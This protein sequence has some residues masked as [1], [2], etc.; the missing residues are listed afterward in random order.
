MRLMVAHFAY[1]QDQGVRVY[2]SGHL[3]RIANT[4]EQFRELQ[5][6]LA[7]G[8]PVTLGGAV[9]DC[10]IHSAAWRYGGAAGCWT[11]WAR[12]SAQAM[13]SNIFSKNLVFQIRR[14]VVSKYILNIQPSRKL[15]VG[16][17]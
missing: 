9:I 1:S 2:D 7:W 3:R 10:R 17:L 16:E 15:V 8:V 4:L 12:R 6:G 14:L 11:G 5:L 13:I